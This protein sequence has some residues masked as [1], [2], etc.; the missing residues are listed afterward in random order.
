MQKAIAVISVF[1]PGTTSVKATLGEVT[2]V[3]N[4]HV[5]DGTGALGK[6]FPVV[7]AKKAVYT[8][9]KD[10]EVTEHRNMQ[11][12]EVSMETWNWYSVVQ[13]TVVK[14][15]TRFLNMPSSSA[16]RQ[17]DMK[18]NDFIKSPSKK[19]KLKGHDRNLELVNPDNLA[20]FILYVED[21]ASTILGRNVTPQDYKLEI[22]PAIND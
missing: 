3:L 20:R 19:V 15:K 21:T 12:V 4:H 6:D 1:L 17:Y 11:R 14:G 22:L 5:Y 10:F 7:S 8:T 2:E 13:K 16:L 9:P 18:E